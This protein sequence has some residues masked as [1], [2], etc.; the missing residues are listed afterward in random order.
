MGH[1]PRLFRE[2]MTIHEHLRKYFFMKW[3][4]TSDDA[5]RR[6]DIA[7]VPKLSLSRSQ[8]QK[9]IKNH[10]LLLN[11]KEAVS[12]VK[13]RERDIV[14][15]SENEPHLIHQGSES[16]APKTPRII[17]ENDEYV[18]I[19]KPAGLLVHAVP[20]KRDETL[21][22][23]FI[24][25]YPNQKNLFPDA[26]R[27]GIVH[28]L[29][30]DVSG[31]LLMA[32]NPRMLDHL[33]QQFKNRLVIKEYTALVHGE[34]KQEEGVIDFP[35]TRSKTRSGAM[36]AKPRNQEGKS[37]LTEY[38]VLE[39]FWH[40]TLLRV[41]IKTGR[42]HQIRAHLK[43]LGYPIVGDRVYALKK[44]KKILDMGRIFLQA[45]RLGF[46]DRAEQLREYRLPLDEFLNRFLQTLKKK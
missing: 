36:A 22:D 39:K 23:W 26:S 2:T 14:E 43:S 1:R 3:I 46:H 17:D 31:L 16:P 10:Q 27:P 42:P 18:V 30:K 35:I 19:D 45:T 8:I 4:I 44:Q 29:D 40:F 32:K 28:R 38:A 15:Y 20:H 7:M 24:K 5:G 12:H 9:S 13:L 33:K 41:T 6:L 11:G 37:A 25:T 21:T 34:V